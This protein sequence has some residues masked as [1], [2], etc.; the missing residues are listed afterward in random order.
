MVG[1]D[2]IGVSIAQSL[3][4]C[5]PTSKMTLIEEEVSCGMHASG[6]NG[7]VPPVGFDYSPDSLK[8][9]LLGRVSPVDSILLSERDLSKL[10]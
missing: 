9:N 10:L 5:Y 8:R 6:R 3:K 2:V 7:G 4:K 1:G